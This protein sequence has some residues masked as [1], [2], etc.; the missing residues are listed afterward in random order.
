MKKFSHGWSTSACA[1]VPS[2]Q[3]DHQMV[4][5]LHAWR[6]QKIHANLQTNERS[7]KANDKLDANTWIC[8][9]RRYV[10]AGWAKIE[11]LYILY[12]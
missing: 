11:I 12:I 4:Q 2:E 5:Q 1:P 7:Q 3:N 8:I 9:W 6:M 10:H